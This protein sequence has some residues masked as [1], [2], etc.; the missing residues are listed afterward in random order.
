[1]N[2]FH[3]VSLWLGRCSGWAQ[4]V[5]M[6]SL[7]LGAARYFR[8]A[9]FS[10]IPPGQEREHTLRE[11]VWSR[12][13][14]LAGALTVVSGRNRKSALRAGELL[15][16]E[17]GVPH[18]LEPSESGVKFVVHLYRVWP[19]TTRDDVAR[20]ENEGGSPQH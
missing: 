6:S 12:I 4:E 16:V 18:H 11:D 20:W 15:D 3:H 9:I 19:D 13:R 1:M 10:A 5:Q 8:S 17:P 14:V 7:P 2:E